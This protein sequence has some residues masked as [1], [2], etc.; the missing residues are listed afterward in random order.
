[1]RIKIKQ[2][3]LVSGDILVLYFSLW[4]MLLIRFNRIP[5]FLLWQ[6]HF[7]SFSAVFIFWLIV[8]YIAGFYGFILK[9]RGL[10]FYWRLLKV[11]GINALVAMSFFYIAPNLIEGLITPKTNIFVTLVIFGA[12]VIL[13]RR[14]FYSFIKSRGLVN[15]LAII[16]VNDQVLEVAQK[17]K[18][19]PGLGYKLAL[20][21]GSELPITYHL[22]PDI[23]HIS[24]IPKAKTLRWMFKKKNIRTIVTAQNPHSDGGLV[25]KLYRCLPLKIDFIDLAHFYES[26]TGKIPVSVIGQVWFLENLKESQKRNYEKIKRIADIFFALG[27]NAIF[28]I[29]SPFVAMAIKIDS[30]GPIFY[31]QKRVGKNGKVYELLKFRSMIKEAENGK[32]EWA[33]EKD[34]RVT[35]VGKFLRITL[36]DELPQIINILKGQMSLVGPRPERPEF[37]KNLAKDIPHYR[38]RHLVKPGMVGWAQ[39]NF[40]YGASKE[41]ALEKLQYDL[42]YLKNRSFLLDLGIFLKTINIIINRFKT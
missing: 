21:I 36:I 42:Y 41:D 2:F 35:R 7:W 26:L 13:W 5:K 40:R 24:T 37:V 22:S 15:N 17:I 4:L 28:L 25:E 1:M 19:N 18:N 16:G 39:I 34:T 14:F 20:I 33:K 8:F 6:Q 32:A 31:R 12:L 9:P 27:L 3:L 10:D 30:P 29:L 11:L 38:V 23:Q